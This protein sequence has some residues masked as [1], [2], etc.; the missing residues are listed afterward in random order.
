MKKM[1]WMAVA[2]AAAGLV[3]RAEESSHWKRAE[4][5]LS[6]MD[7]QKNIEQSF[8]MV[9]KMQVEQLAKLPSASPEEAAKAQAFFNQLMEMISQEMTWEKVKDDYIRIYA[10]TFTEEELDEI[11]KFYQTP[12]GQ[13]LIAKMPELSRRS[14]EVGQKQMTTLLPKIQALSQ[15]MKAKEAAA[16]AA[17]PAATP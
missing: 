15:E 1:L 9:K 13:K 2:L 5:L 17:E 3:A 14:I 10:E 6:M 16:P 4:Q 8:D 7:V 12:V 11:I